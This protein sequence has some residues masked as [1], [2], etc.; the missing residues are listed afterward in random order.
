MA[1][2]EG[3]IYLVVK[4]MLL[5]NTVKYTYYNKVIFGVCYIL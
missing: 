5:W 1:V 3:T 2:T 4:G